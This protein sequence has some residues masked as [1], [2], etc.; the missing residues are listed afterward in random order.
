LEID[1]RMPNEPI[2]RAQLRR[3]SPLVA[4]LNLLLVV[5]AACSDSTRSPG[6]PSPAA[7]VL[8]SIDTLRADYVSFL[9][10]PRQ[11][12]AFLDGLADRGVRFTAAYA[13]SSWTVPSMASL[14]SGLS[15]SSH[16]VVSGRV[17]AA[18]GA[19]GQERVTLQP[20][21]PSSLV[22]LAETF[23]QA[24]YVTI[25]VPSNLHLAAPLGFAQGFDYYGPA[26]F[27]PADQV[28][29]QVMRLLREAFGG[30]WRTA[31]REEKTFLWIHYFDP[32]DPYR[33]R[34]P[35]ANR[36]AA[37]LS[38]QPDRYPANLVMR[39]LHE[40]YPNPDPELAERIKPLYEAEIAYLDQQIRQ[41][42]DEIG[43]DSDGVLLLVT[44]DH[45]EEIV[46]HG[47]IGHGKTLYDEVLRVPLLIYWPDA[48]REGQSIAAATSLLDVFPTLLDLAGLDPP[49]GLQGRSVAAA[50][51]GHG[52][53]PSQ[54]LHFALDRPDRKMT[55]LL[56]G[57]WKL[58][59]R[60]TPSPD[61]QLFD[62]A[63]D[64]RELYDLSADHPEIV[65]RLEA[66]L[67]GRLRALPG[68]PADAGH[69]PAEHNVEGQLRELGYLE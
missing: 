46:D 23:Q 57:D 26:N 21:L 48:I 63:G 4:A 15:P 14:F 18:E 35:W 30:G 20:V 55:A 45:G 54:E 25:G 11:T 12:T 69:L 49:E 52:P 65:A 19:E 29:Q 64:S 34:Q 33:P 37:D 17:D 31:W 40:Q 27:K 10:H 32:H 44:A 51:R 42:N 41:L 66:N 1:A 8:I 61:T 13:P 59:R 53:L 6:D 16:G 24:G 50:L 47:G 43:L 5:P 36:F 58:V 39:R 60:L 3:W 68:P 56:A 62:I 28:N 2:S 9:G 38:T 67:D 7:V 22:T